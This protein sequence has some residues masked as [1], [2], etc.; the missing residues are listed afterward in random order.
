LRYAADLEIVNVPDL[1]L[2][3]GPIPF[4]HTGASDTLWSLCQK[5]YFPRRA[6]TGEETQRQYRYSI[7]SFGRFLGRDP[8][9]AD[10]DDNLLVGWQEQLRATK[11]GNGDPLSAWTINEKV[12]RVRTLWT[13]LAQ[14]RLVER[15]PTVL[16]LKTPELIP[17]ALTHE[18][19]GK[20]FQAADEMPG[21]IGGVRARHWWPAF[22]LFVWSTGERKGASLALRWEWVDFDRNLIVIPAHARKGGKKNGIYPLWPELAQLLDRIKEPKRE[23]VFPDERC[24]T[25][26]YKDWN[27][28]LELAGIPADSKHKTQGL[29]VSH[30]SWIK[31]MGGDPTEALMHGDVATTIRHY[32]DPRMSRAKKRLLFDPRQEASEPETANPIRLDDL[33]KPNG[34]AHKVPRGK[35]LA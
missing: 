12:G 10:L 21:R 3:E 27:K 1:L 34:R 4:A 13:F 17:T 5:V 23:L 14:R 35:L 25:M 26:Y 18:Q 8:V 20:L 9:F 24:G 22:L 7:A 19:L 6:N 33:P 11:K 2:P 30:A 15:F 28:L 31:L 29:R 16:R 32:L